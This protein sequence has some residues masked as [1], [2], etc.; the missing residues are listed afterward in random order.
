[1]INIELLAEALQGTYMSIQGGVQTVLGDD[2]EYEL[3]VEEHEQLEALIFRCG[4]C[5][6]WYE[7]CE[8]GHDL[9]ISCEETLEIELEHD[10]W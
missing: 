10:F 9:C 8:R 1:M 5:E 2:S 3:T 6:T 7:L 4:E